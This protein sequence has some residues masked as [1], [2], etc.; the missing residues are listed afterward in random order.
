MTDVNRN[1]MLYW[2]LKVKH[3]DI[4][5]PKTEIVVLEMGQYNVYDLLDGSEEAARAMDKNLPS[6]KSAIEKVGV[7]AFIRTDYTS[8]KHEWL[9]TCY[10]DAGKGVRQHVAGLV[11][12]SGNSDLM[13]DA[14]A[15]REYIPM[16]TGFT[17][18][19]GRMPVN[20]ERRYFVR[21]GAMECH[22]P[23]WI[24]E[25]VAEGT[26][27]DDLPENWLELLVGMNEESPEEAELLTGY[28]TQIGS[29]IGGYWSV[30][31]CKAKD[32]RWIFIDMAT[33][34]RSWHPGCDK[35]GGN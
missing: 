26:L 6:I 13:I 35:K 25:A 8:G 18:F 27:S 16:Q 14:I 1:S 5:M 12:Y 28:A 2:W 4:P 10:Y 22:H 34:E 3:L 31:F 9:D 30:D 20:P 7:P 17:A 19:T 21:D 15:V 33:G 29:V 32:G 11:R 24:P 23:Y